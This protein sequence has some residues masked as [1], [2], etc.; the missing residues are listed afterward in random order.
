MSHPTTFRVAL[1][2][3]GALS[4]HDRPAI[5]RAMLAMDARTRREAREAV[6]RLGVPQ[7]PAVLRREFERLLGALPELV[8]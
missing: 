1:A 2:F 6:R 7:S 4:R 5:A 3:A 8:R